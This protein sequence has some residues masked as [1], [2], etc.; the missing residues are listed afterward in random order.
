MILC[1]R[2]GAGNLLDSSNNFK[3]AADSV[4]FAKYMMFPFIEDSNV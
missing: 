3:A 4:I 1:V 2:P